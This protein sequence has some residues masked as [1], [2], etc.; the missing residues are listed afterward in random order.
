MKMKIRGFLVILSVFMIQSAFAQDKEVSGTVVDEDGA[1]L[2][3][4]NITVEQTDKGTQTDF[5]GKYTIEVE[6]GATL[7]YSFVGFREKTETVGDEDVI[8]VIMEESTS[9]LGEV[10]VTGFQDIDEIEF[11]GASQKVEAEDIDLGG[12]PDISSM[13]QGQVSG[14][15]VTNVSGSFG[16]APDI[17]IRGASSIMGDTRPLWVIDGAVQEGITNVDVNDL[18]SGDVNTLLGSEV[19]GLNPSDIKSIEI[20]KDASATAQYGARALNGVI[21]VETKSGKRDERTSVDYRAEFAFRPTPSYHKFDRLNSQEDLSVYRELEEKG[22]LSIANTLQNRYGGLYNLMYRKINDFGFNPED[23]EGEGDF[24]VTNTP[25]EKAKF[26]Q[27]Y[28]GNNTD[29]FDVLFRPIP[30]ETHTLSLT[31]GSENSTSYASFSYYTDPG[32]TTADRVDRLTGNIKNSY[33]FA[34]DKVKATFKLNTSFR[35]QKAPGTFD[36]QSD[37][38]FGEIN[39]DF[40]INPFSYALNTSRALRPYDDNGDFEYLRYNWAPF[41]IIDELHKNETDI[42]VHDIKFQAGVEADILPKLKYNFLGTARYAASSREHRIKDN[43]NAA[44]AYRAADNTIIRD[45]NN[46]LYDDP[47]RPDEHPRVV[48]PDGGILNTTDNKIT[49]YTVRNSLEYSK[50]INDK[51][52]L[53]LYLGQEYRQTDREERFNRG[54]GLQFEKGNTPFIDPDIIRKETESG[55]DYYGLTETKERGVSFF[56]NLTY[57]FDHKYIVNAVANYEGSNRAGRSS[58]ARWLPTFNFSGRWNIDRETFIENLDWVDH[59]SLRAGYGVVGIISDAASNNLPIFINDITDRRDQ[60]TRENFIGISDLQNEDLTYEKTYETNVGFD[61]GMFDNRVNLNTNFYYRKG[62]DLIDEV[63]TSGIGGQFIKLGNNADMTTKGIEFEL[64]T[65]NIVTDDFSWS[66]NLNLSA[67]DQKITKLLKKPTV[68]DLV[69]E[70]GDAVKGFSQASIW[71]FDFDKLNE[72]GLPTY[73]LGE[74]KDGFSDI[75]FQ[76]TEDITDYLVHEGPRDPDLTG[77]I[78]NTFRYKNFSLEF[79]ITFAAGNVVRLTPHYSGTYND[80]DV[81]SEDF[82][83]RW[84][85]PGDEEITNVPAIPS[86]QMRSIYGSSDVDRAYNAYNY[87]TERIASGSYVRMRNIKLSYSFPQSLQDKLSLNQ[88]G[89]TVQATNPFLIYSDHKLHGQDP[90]FVN[91]GGVASPVA[92]QYTLTLN[93]G[94]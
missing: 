50:S 49:T 47:T 4:V 63:R 52:N 22:Y 86:T 6:K 40:D 28:E 68:M 87:S 32:R 81:F 27:K 29:W 76:E 57:D 35:D 24:G 16:A 9:E 21:V 19:A 10:V 12:T 37:D 82:T 64:N 46:F 31:G 84:L 51:H 25:E 77:G 73:N 42:K 33:F 67:F 26:L 58:S 71:S 90:E 65:K 69:T 38:V 56:S 7:K 45:A 8:D 62:K 94:F 85:I 39:R 13:L 78:G 74:D 88:L 11:T 34:D 70:T 18:A 48:M 5:D 44:E 2:P 53:S 93:V 55:R 43:A 15:N 1:P 75:D 30:T 89:L 3:G 83:D 92:K 60:S 61:L 36:R 20:L 54:F 91:S 72:D 41:N 79:F 66:T 59:L 23:P 14:V 17:T 80:L